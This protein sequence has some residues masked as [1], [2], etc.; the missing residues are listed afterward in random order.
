MSNKGQTRGKGPA[1]GLR[2]I[3]RLVSIGRY[4]WSQEVQC[5]IEDGEFEPED[6]ERCIATGTVTKTNKDALGDSIGQKVYTIIGVDCAGCS[7]Y[8]AGKIIKG[9]DEQLYFFITAHPST[10]R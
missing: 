7:F 4:D 3:R 2:S 8:T 5:A 6:L 9:L 1:G 10:R